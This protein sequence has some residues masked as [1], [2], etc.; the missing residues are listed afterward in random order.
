M[1]TAGASSWDQRDTQLPPQAGTSPAQGYQAQPLKKRGSS[2]F[3]PSTGAP[4]EGGGAGRA[5]HRVGTPRRSESTG[6]RPECALAQPWHA[7]AARVRKLLR[8]CSGL[9]H[10]LGWPFGLQAPGRRGRGHTP[11][12]LWAMLGSSHDL[13]L[14]LSVCLVCNHF[15]VKSHSLPVQHMPG[16]AQFWAATRHPCFHKGH[17]PEGPGQPGSPTPGLRGRDT[18]WSLLMRHECEEPRPTWVPFSSP[19]GDQCDP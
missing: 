10:W 18:P 4:W 12:A 6:P 8:L 9:H 14:W 5:D 3:T 17:I 2:A 1:G 7:Q 11:R 19:Q 16:L 13:F 15:K